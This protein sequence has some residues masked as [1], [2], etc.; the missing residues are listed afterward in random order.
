MY[1][2]NNRIRRTVVRAGQGPRVCPRVERATTMG[3]PDATTTGALS[4]QCRT[5][6]EVYPERQETVSHPP[7][8]S[9]RVGDLALV[10]VSRRAAP[11]SMPPRAPHAGAFA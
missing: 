5:G 9:E 6:T 10:E 11:H 4:M 8:A 7:Q 2:L 1:R 3:G